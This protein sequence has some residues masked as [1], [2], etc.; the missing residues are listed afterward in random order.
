MESTDSEMASNPQVKDT[1]LAG[2]ATANLSPSN[3]EFM[4]HFTHMNDFQDVLEDIDRDLS[5]YDLPLPENNSHNIPT[6]NITYPTSPHNIPK[7]NDPTSN[8]K[9]HTTSFQNTHDLH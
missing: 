1:S 7:T 4:P 8:T 6:Q 9:I 2:K 3:L 5:K